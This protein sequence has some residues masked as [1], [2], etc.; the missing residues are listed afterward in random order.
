MQFLA[1]NLILGQIQVDFWNQCNKI[2]ILVP[3]HYEQVPKWRILA[4]AENGGLAE[5]KR[6]SEILTPVQMFGALE[7][8][9]FMKSLEKQMDSSCISSLVSLFITCWW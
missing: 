9:H 3:L 2:H 8:Y 6:Y 1:L 7:F 5:Q 4:M